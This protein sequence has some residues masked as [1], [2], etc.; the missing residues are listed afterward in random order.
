V[1]RGEEDA[2]ISAE[3]AQVLHD[4]IPGSRLVTLPRIGHLPSLED[5]AA[6]EAALSGFLDTLKC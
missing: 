3:D 2:L 6:F 5:P 4:G 1:I